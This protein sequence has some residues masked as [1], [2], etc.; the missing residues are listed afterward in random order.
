[1]N[2]KGKSAA[3]EADMHSYQVRKRSMVVRSTILAV[4]ASCTLAV[5]SP[6]AA[7]ALFTGAMCGVL[8]ALLSMYGN[9]R[10]LDHRSIASFV[11]GSVLR[12]GIFGIVPVEFGLHGPWWTIGVCFIGFFTPLS[13]YALEYARTVHRTG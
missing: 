11:F 7:V 13:L 4:V 6:Y 3:S 12:I 8:N 9:E 5:W 10:L 2:D 1:M